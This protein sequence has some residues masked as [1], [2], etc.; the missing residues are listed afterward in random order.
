MN[1]LIV[2]DEAPARS[3]LKRMLQKFEDIV[4]VGEAKNG[5]EAL[6][7]IEKLKPDVVFLDIEMPELDGFGVADAIQ[8]KGPNVVFVTAFSEFALK[9]FEVAAVD[10]LVKPVSEERLAAA[11]KKL[12]TRISKKQEDYSKLLNI[13][14][15]QQSVRRFA[16]RCGSKYIVLDP[17][18]I[19][20][21]LAR[22]HY[23]AIIS[24]GKELLA[25]DSLD[26][27]A[28]RL[29]PQQF[30]RIH[31][32]GVINVEFLKELE[33]EGDRKYLAILNDNAKTKVPISRERLD[34]LKLRLGIE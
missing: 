5:I 19:S 25:D 9:A 8:G 11:V 29:N 20:A 7:E 2:D 12:L 26:I 22:D 15:Q 21:I 4:V 14:K 10:Y 28:N 32:S 1:A 33:R 23:A 27:L 3:R 6:E 17:S 13:L 30:I 18:K 24:D 34:D 31:R 16:V